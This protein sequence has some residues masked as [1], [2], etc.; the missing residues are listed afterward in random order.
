MKHE[1]TH[2]NVEAKLIESLGMEIGGRMHTTRSRN[3]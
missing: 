1:D 3:D 2:L